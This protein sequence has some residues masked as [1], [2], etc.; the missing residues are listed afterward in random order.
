[1]IVLNQEGFKELSKHSGNPFLDAMTDL[2][3]LFQTLAIYQQNKEYIDKYSDA[4]LSDLKDKIKAMIPDAVDAKGNIDFSKIEALA[5]QGDPTAQSII[6]TRNHRKAFA[7]APLAVKFNALKNPGVVDLLSFKIAD[8]NEKI[9]KKQELINETIK[10]SNL[11]DDQKAIF[12]AFSSRIAQDPQTLKTIIPLL[13]SPTTVDNIG[14]S[15][16]NATANTGTNADTN[17]SKQ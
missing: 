4:N 17:N 14:A 10:N 6:D 12:S 1:M 13:I 5:S 2:Q 9:K 8:K 16:T 7:D 15:N 11:P 3:G